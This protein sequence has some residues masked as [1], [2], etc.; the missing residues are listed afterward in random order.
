MSI[1]KFRKSSR[2]FTLALL[3][4]GIG[5]LLP[6]T[7]LEE[8][9]TN[10]GLRLLT[11][12][13]AAAAC[14]LW[15]W[16]LISA[17]AA[18]PDGSHK[19]WFGPALWWWRGLV[20]AMAVGMLFPGLGAFGPIVLTLVA[21]VFGTLG[22]MTLIRLLRDARL[23]VM[24][25]TAILVVGCGLIQIGFASVAISQIPSNPHWMAD[26]ADLVTLWVTAPVG[27]AVGL[28]GLI[29]LYAAGKDWRG[30]R[31]APAEEV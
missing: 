2:R 8:G 10:F 19:P 4:T 5:F 1:W 12:S 30:E 21:V 22:L 31:R 13:F 7:T 15:G 9:T 24:L 23:S 27:V 17:T 28:A 6:P 26:N 25:T 14:A 16:V 3:L 20:A 29:G 18:L 11:T